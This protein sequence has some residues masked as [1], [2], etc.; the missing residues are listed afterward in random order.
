MG[1]QQGGG[2]SSSATTG[3][4]QQQ[5]TGSSSATTS[6]SN[7]SESSTATTDKVSIVVTATISGIAS[8]HTE[9]VANNQTNL[10]NAFKTA[11]AAQVTGLSSSGVCAKS[12][13][14]AV[15]K[16]YATAAA[17]CA[18]VTYTQD[19]S[20]SR[21]SRR[22]LTGTEVHFSADVFYS[23]S[24]TFSTALE[25]YGNSASGTSQVSALTTSLTTAVQAYD[26]SATVTGVT[27]TATVVP[28]GGSGGTTSNAITASISMGA[29]LAMLSLMA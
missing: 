21:R 16:E 19:C 24:S 25:T 7:S 28:T 12:D 9:F 23:S 15:V 10:N 17:T 18:A 26:S 5:S 6:S 8:T 3:N 13:L 29:L 4:Q 1:Q 20:S 11:I 14:C 27:A 22:M 2:S